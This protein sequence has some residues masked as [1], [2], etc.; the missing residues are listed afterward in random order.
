MRL[1]Y[2]RMVDRL[3]VISPGFDDARFIAQVPETSVVF[4]GHFPG[5]QIMPGVM[6]LESM[7]QASGYMLAARNKGQAMPFFAGVRKGKFRTFV[8]P[9]TLMH[10]TATI[11]HEGSGFAVTSASIEIGGKRTAESELTLKLV[12]FPTEILRDAFLTE[13]RRIG[14]PL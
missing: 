1:E 12:P 4:E 14:V 5:F 10:V 8:V 3:E 6:L 9:G 13:A 11:L 2:F 7:A